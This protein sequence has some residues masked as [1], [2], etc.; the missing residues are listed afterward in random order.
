MSSHNRIGPQIKIWIQSGQYQRWKHHMSLTVFG[1]KVVYKFWWPP[2][3]LANQHAWT[4][5]GRVVKL[6][7]CADDFTSLSFQ[8]ATV[9]HRALR[10]PKSIE[11]LKHDTVAVKSFVF[12]LHVSDS[13]RSYTHI[14]LQWG[15]LA[16][17]LVVWNC[18]EKNTKVSKSQKQF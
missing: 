14:L 17:W 6:H 8:V 16:K 10:K 5:E 3:Q 13:V 11:I 15:H 9:K 18:R 12:V 2:L 7:V 1:R 4:V